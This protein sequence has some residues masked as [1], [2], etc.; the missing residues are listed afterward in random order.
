MGA[1]LGI[2]LIPPSPESSTHVYYLY[3]PHILLRDKGCLISRSSTS[4][5]AYFVYV[6]SHFYYWPSIYLI[7]S[8][9][10]FTRRSKAIHSINIVVLFSPLNNKDGILTVLSVSLQ[11]NVNHFVFSSY[12]IIYFHNGSRVQINTK[13]CCFCILHLIL[14]YK[15]LVLTPRDLKLQL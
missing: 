2:Y 7:S 10:V 12:I 13:L 6:F 9:F 15:E 11:I 1:F 14:F 4:V 3:Y 5:T 8:Y